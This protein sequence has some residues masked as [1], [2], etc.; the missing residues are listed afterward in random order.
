MEIATFGFTSDSLIGV[1]LQIA[2]ERR[3]S[4]SEVLCV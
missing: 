4:S 1:A 2:L 3:R